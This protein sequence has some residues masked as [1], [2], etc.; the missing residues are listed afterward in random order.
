MAFYVLICSTAL[1][2]IIHISGKDADTYCTYLSRFNSILT[3]LTLKKYRIFYEIVLIQ[4]T[5]SWFMCT[6]DSCS[7]LDCDMLKGF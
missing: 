4:D 6:S 3:L 2:Y 7:I 1:T 5:K